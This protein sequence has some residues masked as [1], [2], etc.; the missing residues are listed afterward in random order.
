MHIITIGPDGIHL[1]SPEDIAEMNRLSAK[2]EATR[3]DCDCVSPANKLEPCQATLE[4]PDA[5]RHGYWTCTR[6]KGHEGKHRAC[7]VARHNRHEWYEEK[8]ITE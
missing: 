5:P 1:M 8:G 2:H 7:G 4:H 6:P 3:G